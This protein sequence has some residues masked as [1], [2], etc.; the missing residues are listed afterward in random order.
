MVAFCLT[1]PFKLPVCDSWDF[2]LK[3][4]LNSDV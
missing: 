1:K 2:I 3:S 4:S